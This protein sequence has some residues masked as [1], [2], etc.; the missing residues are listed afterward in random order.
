MRVLHLVRNIGD[1]RAFA[2]AVQQQRLGH[3]VTLLLLHDAVLSAPPFS[4][5]VLACQDDLRARQLEGKY[6]T[7][8]YD[9]IVRMISEHDKVLSW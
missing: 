1:E 7:V 3:E 9:G 4:G 6:P 8:D 5:R 2:T